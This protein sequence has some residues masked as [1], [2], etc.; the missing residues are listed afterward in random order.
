MFVYKSIAVNFTE[1]IPNKIAGVNYELSL[2]ATIKHMLRRTLVPQQVY[3]AFSSMVNGQ[4]GSLHPSV[5]TIHYSPFT[6][7]YKDHS[8]QKICHLPARRDREL[9]YTEW[10]KFS[11]ITQ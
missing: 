8:G 9:V 4:W 10:E 2:S 5:F 11:T 1:T 6:S 3:S 7:L